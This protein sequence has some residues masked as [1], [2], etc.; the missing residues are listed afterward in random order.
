MNRIYL[1]AT[2]YGEATRIKSEMINKGYEYVYGDYT[3]GEYILGFSK[4]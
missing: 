2:G 4:H 1:T 3:D